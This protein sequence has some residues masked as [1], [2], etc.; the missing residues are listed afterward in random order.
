MNNNK[1]L[2]PIS[3]VVAAALIAGAIIYTQSTK[4]TVI[5]SEPTDSA[6][7]LDFPKVTT[8]DHVRGSITSAVQMIEYSDTECPFCKMFHKTM[9]K[10]TEQ[11]GKNNSV[12]WTY[13]HF[14][15]PQLHSKAPKQSEA[16]E[17]VAKL[18]GEEKFWKYLD[19]IYEKTPSNNGLDHTLLSTWAQELGVNKNNFDQCLSSGEFSQKIND[20]FNEARKIGAQGTPYTII[21]A[22]KPV[23]KEAVRSLNDLFTIAATKMQV[24]PDRLGSV[25]KDGTVTLNGALQYEFIAQVLNILLAI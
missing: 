18:G 3:I 5:P 11:Y 13:R 22:Q 15:I 19:T 14:P 17:C 24:T 10:I 12:S 23:P 21:K 20:S 1:F 8:A 4:S 9:K 2:V 16:T 25:A 6:S 7:T